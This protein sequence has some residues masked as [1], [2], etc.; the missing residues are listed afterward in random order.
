[1]KVECVQ[2]KIKNAIGL[3]ERIAGKNMTLPV[4]SCV[5]LIA[6]KSNLTIRSTNLDLGIEII[7]PAKVEVEGS[8]AVPGGILNNLLGTLGREKTVVLE[9]EGGN[10]KVSA[11]KTSSVVKAVPHEDFPIIPKVEEESVYTIKAMDISQGLKSVVYSAS[12]SAVKPELSSVYMYCEADYVVFVATDSFRLAEK[13]V[14]VK[15]DKEFSPIIIPLRN[16][17]ELIKILDT[18]HDDVTLVVSRNQI[19]FSYKGLYVVSRVVDGVFPD[20]R[21][22]IPKEATTEATALTQDIQDTLKV[23]T[24]FSDKFNQVNISV[25]PKTKT[26]IFKTKN[27][28]VGEIEKAIDATI[29]GEPIAINFN[30]RYISDCLQ[31]IEGDS[32]T[33]KFTTLNRPMVIKS[34]SD[35]TFTYL[36]MPMNR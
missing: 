15:K 10:L 24:I 17:P 31:S 7:V 12:L 5:L 35:P 4:L 13:K 14:R 33:L 8:V 34:V 3:A 30:H 18:M 19:A 20:Y 32:L 25:D 16:V 28:D 6:D 29:E 21:Q 27:N 11:Q 26:C 23:S 9:V 1:M 2:E 22:I 36:V